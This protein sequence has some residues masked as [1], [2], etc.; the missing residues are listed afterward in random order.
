[1]PTFAN[2]WHIPDKEIPNIICI[3]QTTEPLFLTRTTSNRKMMLELT[4]LVK[5]LV[6]N[7]TPVEKW[8]M[9]AQHAPPNS[10]L[11]KINM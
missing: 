1:M 8:Q 7:R 2:H 10:N 4:Q 11:S 5:K 6:E 9:W 3:V